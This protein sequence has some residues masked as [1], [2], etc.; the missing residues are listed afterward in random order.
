MCKRPELTDTQ[1]KKLAAGKCITPFCTK[2]KKQRGRICASCAIERYRKNH[3]IK[4]AYQVLK[5]NAKRR[6]KEFTLSFT[7][8]EKLVKD[9]DYM[10][11]KGTKSKSLQ[12]DRVDE[13]GGYSDIN[14]QC[15][16]LR[17]NRYK[18]DRFRQAKNYDGTPVDYSNVPF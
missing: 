18:Y 16:T 17:E 5:N 1:K 15:I 4:Y 8:F 7:Y 13:L 14:V 11:K 9:N 3:P 12:V 10:N 2:K 6:G